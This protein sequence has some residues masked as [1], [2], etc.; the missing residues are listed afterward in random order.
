MKNLERVK[1]DNGL[2]IYLYNDPRKHSTF[3][4]LVTKLGSQTKDFL[5][6][7][8]EYHLEDGIA[9]LLEHYVVEASETGNYVELL[10]KEHMITNANTDLNRTSYFFAT[11]V[12]LLKGLKIFLNCCYSTK[13][14]Q[15][16]LDEVKKAIYEE[17]R[18]ENDGKFFHFH[19]KKWDGLF[20]NITYRS[21]L[22]TLEYIKSVDIN[23]LK[24]VH[25]AF[26]QPK[27]QLLIIAGNFN[28]RNIL[29][30]IKSFYKNLEIKTHNTQII[31][32]KEP[33]E[34]KK[35][36]GT[37]KVNT[38]QDYGNVCFKINI[39]KLNDL[40]RYKLDFYLHYFLRLKFGI[41][42]SLYKELVE[43]KIIT[44]SLDY[45]DITIN[46]YLLVSIGCYSN[47]PKKLTDAILK[48]I[49]NNISIEKEEF[50]LLNIHTRTRISMRPE[51]ITLM[52][53]TL[54][55]NILEFN[56][57]NFDTVEMIDK[58]SFEEYN[59]LIAKLNF[60]NYTVTYMKNK[61][62]KDAKK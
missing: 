9:H 2:E 39:S 6:D 5:V 13:F 51:H 25:N 37:V 60:S 52:A 49:N 31:K 43:K 21:G 40:E 50:E 62:Q 18:A 59:S 29:K 15:E 54:L 14:T 55:D 58:F 45:S 53:D 35:K 57:C 38:A 42:S 61:Y 24:D 28:K 17:I 20:H 34:V 8:K 1:L 27:N 30:E 12:N 48:E 3:V 26:Y 46:D 41:T 7:G 4:N 11:S 32:V 36:T 33:E 23:T 10:G 22:G 19:T 56:Y 47:Y 44:Y 16:K